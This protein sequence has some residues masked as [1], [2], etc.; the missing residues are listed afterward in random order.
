VPLGV[1]VVVALET[2]ITQ[3]GRAM[4]ISEV[5]TGSSRADAK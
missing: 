3:G 2:R 4:Q 1:K 5:C